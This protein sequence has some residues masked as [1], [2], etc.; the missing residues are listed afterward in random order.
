MNAATGLLAGSNLSFNGQPAWG[1]WLDG[2][3]RHRSDRPWRTCGRLAGISAPG[4]A[5]LF[6]FVDEAPGSIGNGSFDVSMVV[7]T[8]MVSWPATYHNFAAS[9]SF[10]DGHGESHKW[11][12]G[13]T[14]MTGTRIPAS[15]PVP[16]I[17][18]GP[19]NQD[20]L[21]LQRHTS[22]HI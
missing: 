18:T 8:S 19:D 7:P 13:R 17:Q 11:R 4:P 22:S 9:F 2:T 14:K 10:L 3:G 20:I 6:M 12:D 1:P 15:V 5:E 21:W 16:V